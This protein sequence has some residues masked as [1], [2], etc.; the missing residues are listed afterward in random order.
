MNNEE[1]ERIIIPD[2]HGEEHLFNVVYKFDIDETGYSYVALTPAEQWDQKQADQGRLEKESSLIGDTATS[3]DREEENF[4][5]YVFRIEEN[6]SD[7]EDL[8]LFQ[9]E[10]D[11]EWDIIEETLATLEDY[12][13]I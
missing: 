10:S 4:E 12:D 1:Q 7:E 3:D 13:I 11:E 5:L 9:I 2:E 8:Q 6:D